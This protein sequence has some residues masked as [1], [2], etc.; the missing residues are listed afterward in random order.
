MKKITISNLIDFGRKRNQ[1]SQ[2]TLLNNI[3][4]PKKEK[5]DNEG[6]GNYWMTS[7]ST[8]SAVYKTE[9]KELIEE[10][11]LD[12]TNRFKRA[13]TKRSKDMYVKNIEILKNFEE[14]EMKDLKPSTKITMLTKPEEKSVIQICGLPVQIR[15]HHIY[16]FEEKGKPMVGGIWFVA[17]KGGYSKDE[18]QM[19][20]D[21]IF[22]YMSTHH[23]ERFTV[24]PKFCVAVDA[25]STNHSRYSDIANNETHSLI[26]PTLETIKKML[27]L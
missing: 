9:N 12:I 21:A 27:G 13:S 17:K 3:K 18:L 16:S 11:I 25:F 8:I 4:K 14:F 22:R 2:L 1:N 19:F 23:S 20:T 26:D 7:L 15:P 24:H 10:K 5:T 6:G